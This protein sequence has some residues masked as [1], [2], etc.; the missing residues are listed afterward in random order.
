MDGLLL[1]SADGGGGDVTGPASSTDNEIVR[2]H[3]TTG[4]VLQTYTSNPPTISDTGDVNID[5]DLDVE[6]IVVSGLVDGKDVSGLATAAEAV[7]AVEAADAGK[8]VIEVALNA[9]TALAVTDKA[10]FRIPA[11][12]NGFNLVAVAAMCKVASTTGAV[13]ITIKNAATSMLSTNI[14]IDQDEFDTLTAATPAVIN[15]ATDDVATGAQI[16]VAVTGAGA[17]VTYCV[18]ELTFAKP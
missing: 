10:Y 7:A 4:K 14:T 8:R 5:G 2:Q 6:N 11:V 3:S 13:T 16:E 17:A 9:G 12:M 1:I 18:V 15:G